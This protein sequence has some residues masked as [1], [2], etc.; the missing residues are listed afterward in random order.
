VGRLFHPLCDDFGARGLRQQIY[1]GVPKL[2]KNSVKFTYSLDHSRGYSMR[3]I[4]NDKLDSHC[5]AIATHTQLGIRGV[6]CYALKTT[7]AAALRVPW[8]TIILK[9]ET[10]CDHCNFDG[11]DGIPDVT[12]PTAFLLGSTSPRCHRCGCRGRRGNA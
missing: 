11:F 4:G 8:S 9:I 10:W 3:R 5:N 7:S 1:Y 2:Y 6:F 12:S